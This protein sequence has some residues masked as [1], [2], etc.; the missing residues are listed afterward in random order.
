MQTTAFKKFIVWQYLFPAARRSRDP[1]SG[2]M[3]RHHAGGR[4]LQRA[5]KKAMMKLGVKNRV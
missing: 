2:M 5:V 4:S 1:R 3:R